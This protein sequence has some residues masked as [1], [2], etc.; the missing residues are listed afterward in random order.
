MNSNFGGIMGIFKDVTK[1]VKNIFSSDDDMIFD[2]ENELESN[3][4]N[5]FLRK[6]GDKKSNQG[7]KPLAPAFDLENHGFSMAKANQNN[8][9]R[10]NGKIQ[11]YVPKTFEEA[12]NIIKDVKAGYTAMVNVEVASPQISTRL[13]DVVS[14]A[15]YA[16][17]GDCKKMG[18]KQYIFSLSTETIG[19]YDYLPV[20]GEQNA[21]EQMSGFNFGRAPGF[22]FSGMQGNFQ[23]MNPAPMNQAPINMPQAGQINY[24]NQMNQNNFNQNT[25]P[26]NNFNPNAFNKVNDRPA[27]DPQNVYVPP[28]SQF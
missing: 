14:G 11:I 15:I 10:S 23:T 13:I 25:F 22:D 19:A 1:T 4:Q 5:P 26:Q 20:N 17:D 18:E 12:F 27:M 6:L 7:N 2:D 28:K 9:R 24:G 8:N 3:E 16:L 21:R